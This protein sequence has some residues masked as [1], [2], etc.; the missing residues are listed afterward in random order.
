MPAADFAALLDSI[1]S[2]EPEELTAAIMRICGTHSRGTARSQQRQIGL[3]EIGH[4]C[5]RSVAYRLFEH[6]QVNTDRD[7]HLADVGTAWHA[8]LADAF[9]AENRR[10]GRDRWLIEQRVWLTDGYSGTCDL[11]DVDTARVV[12]HKLLGIGS[13]RKIRDGEI[14]AHY[15]QQIHS[16]GYGH[17]RAGR[18]VR[19][20]ALACYPRSDNLG[21]NFGGGGLHIHTEPYSEGVA[22]AGLDRLGRLS[23]LGYQLDPEQHPDRWALI[24]ATPGEHCSYCPFFRSNGG[25]ADASGCPGQPVAAPTSMPGIL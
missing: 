3:S 20:V 6:P 18:P 23:A 8:W 12:D 17:T 24:A 19:E 4:L 10:L 16:Y 13:L 14:P 9:A 25:P 2:P 22:L 5:D 7:N 11:Y 21:G 1:T 15:R